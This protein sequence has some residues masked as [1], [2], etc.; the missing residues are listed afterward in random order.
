MEEDKLT[1]EEWIKRANETIMDSATLC[2]SVSPHAGS[3]A[4][5]QRERMKPR[6]GIYPNGDNV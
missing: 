3:E 6:L 5:E 2:G 1:T 4:V